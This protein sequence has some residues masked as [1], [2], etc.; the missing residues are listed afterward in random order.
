MRVCMGESERE[1]E[2]EGGSKSGEARMLE[3]KLRKFTD[4]LDTALLAFALYMRS[5]AVE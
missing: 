2:K 4:S 3:N 5:R 1:T